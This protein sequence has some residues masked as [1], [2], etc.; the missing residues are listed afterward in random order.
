MHLGIH[1]FKV[2]IYGICSWLV[3]NFCSLKMYFM[4]HGK[5][6][7]SQF[8]LLSSRVFILFVRFK[9]WIRLNKWDSQILFVNGLGLFWNAYLA[10]T[11]H[12]LKKN[13]P[14]RSLIVTPVLVGRHNS[15]EKIKF[16]TRALQLDC[17]VWSKKIAIFSPYSFINYWLYFLYHSKLP[18]NFY[19]IKQFVLNW[20]LEKQ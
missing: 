1:E 3:L 10:N 20:T 7:D 15:L 18:W 8:K 5:F 12:N 17:T 2:L 14:I 4:I 11:N 6:T 9:V 19:S 16:L 13:N